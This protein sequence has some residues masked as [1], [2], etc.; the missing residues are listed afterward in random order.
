MADFTMRRMCARRA[1]TSPSGI[2]LTFALLVCGIGCA[3]SSSPVITPSKPRIVSMSPAVTQMLIELGFRDQIVGVG[4][5]DPIDLPGVRVVG[6]SV[7]LDYEKL[8]AAR[9]TH[10]F[11]QPER[12]VG[13]PER[14]TELAE[15]HHWAVGTVQI[16]T[17]D[18]ALRALY[19][20]ARPD[21]CIGGYLDV[22]D[23]AAALRTRIEARLAG[24][25]AWSAGLA[26][27]DR[28]RVLIVFRTD[29]LGVVGRHTFLDDMLTT[30]GG[31]N[32]I[33]AGYYISVDRERVL[34][35]SPDVVLLL[36]SPGEY[37]DAQLDAWRATMKALD[38]P[39]AKSDRIEVL[40]DPLAK[41]P[42]TSVATIAA[43]IARR[44]H[45]SR[46]KAIDHAVSSDDAVESGATGGSSA[47]DTRSDDDALAGKPPV[48]P[49]PSAPKASAPKPA[50]AS[51]SSTP[52][53][54]GTP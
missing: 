9:P 4:R 20:P 24:L 8:A 30:A 5:Y 26:D 43:E 14:L 3:E 31:V 53:P 19:D 38:I 28:P 41:I 51:T 42:S 2:G 50:S 17:V 18:D 48:A 33:D 37:T 10:V 12:G 35:A 32:A 39:A 21:A 16:D 27:A 34:A 13:V 47:S 22:S 40:R 15:H 29:P 44:L 6:D 49:E 25:R 45:P 7:H 54:A 52:Q 11:L 46:V 23:A 1:L 36:T